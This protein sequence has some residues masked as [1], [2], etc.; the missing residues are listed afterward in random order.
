MKQVF[1]DNSM[2]LICKYQTFSDID[3]KKLRYGLEGIYLTLTKTIVLLI[4]SICLNIL[5]EFLLVLLF[6][7]VIRYT[8]FGFHAKKSSQCLFISILDFIVIPYT[9]FHIYIPA[10]SIYVILAICI[11]HFILFAPADTIKRPL[12]NKRKRI[13]RKLLTIMIGL[14]YTFII[15][16]SHNEWISKILLATMMIE[17]I[18]IHP[19]LYK[20]FGQPYGNY[21]KIKH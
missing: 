5:K 3:Q 4:L 12:T 14:I 2:N 7:N 21:K 16:F 15:V 13:I 6:F 9:L 11:I 8:G 1:L 17:A 10:N 20:A 18:N 19:L